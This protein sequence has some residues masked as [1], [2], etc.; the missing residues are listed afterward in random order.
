LIYFSADGYTDPFYLRFTSGKQT[1]MIIGTSRSAQGILPTVINKDLNRSDMYNFSFT[2][3]HSPFGESYLQLIEK[4][5]DK[6]TKSG[7]FI[8]AVDPWSISSEF[9]G[10]IELIPE[11]ETFT[12]KLQ[13]VNLNPNIFYLLNFYDGNLLKI[14][15]P[16]RHKNTFLHKDGSL[17]VTIPMDNKSIDERVSSKAKEYVFNQNRYKL[18]EYR[19]YHL[20]KTIKFL[21]NYGK[22]VLV[23]I[24]IH[25]KIYE[26]EMSY[27]SHFNFLIDKIATEN[28]VN[29]IDYTHLN[30][31][32]EYTDG[33][34]LSRK[35]AILFTRRI[36]DSL[37][38]INK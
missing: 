36:T 19:M 28:K 15:L 35:S 13:F 32:L 1:S 18:S 33:N 8:I 27:C 31:S 26:I 25:P 7:L 34:H 9:K 23:R 10:E 12:G 3:L 14:M 30:D 37:K 4:K 5:L 21:K 6:N 16:K 11:K 22:V 20:E 29:Y 24:P 2:L 17:E 38:I